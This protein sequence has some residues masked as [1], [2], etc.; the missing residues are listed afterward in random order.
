MALVLVLEHQ[1]QQHPR[2]NEVVL[3]VKVYNFYLPLVREGLQVEAEQPLE[4][5]VEGKAQEGAAEAEA[6]AAPEAVEAQGLV[7]PD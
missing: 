5:E 2:Q 4:E 1:I 3:E 7:F 6:E